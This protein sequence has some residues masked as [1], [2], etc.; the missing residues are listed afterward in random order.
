[1]REWIDTKLIEYVIH[2]VISISLQFDLLMFSFATNRFILSSLSAA[3]LFWLSNNV[4][5]ILLV[6]CGYVCVRTVNDLPRVL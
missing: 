2:S 4:S 6:D 1:M 5:L 3:Y